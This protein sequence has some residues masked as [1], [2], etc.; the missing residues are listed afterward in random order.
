MIGPGGV[1][2]TPAT[3]PDGVGTGDG[4]GVGEVRAELAV[5]GTTGLE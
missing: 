3:D 4:D 2:K 5:V 1:A